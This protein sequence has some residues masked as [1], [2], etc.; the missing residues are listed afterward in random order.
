MWRFPASEGRF[1]PTWKNNAILLLLKANHS[2]D[3][4]TIRPCD[5]IEVDFL[6]KLLQPHRNQSGNIQGLETLNAQ[7]QGR[8][9]APSAA[10]R[11]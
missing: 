8:R 4:P 2:S 1:S 11:C 10:C 7:H 9:V 3:K 5:R 6:F